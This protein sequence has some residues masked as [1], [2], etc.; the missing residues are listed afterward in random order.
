MNTKFYKNEV[1]VDWDN[2]KTRRLLYDIRRDLAAVDLGTRFYNDL[3]DEYASEDYPQYFIRNVFCFKS[4]ATALPSFWRELTSLK[5]QEV[6]AFFIYWGILSNYKLINNFLTINHCGP[7]IVNVDKIRNKIRN[8]INFLYFY[9]YLDSITL[10][11]I[12]LH[13]L[14]FSYIFFNP[15]VGKVF[16]KALSAY[17]DYYSENYDEADLYQ[18]IAD[19][20]INRIFG[21]EM[22]PFWQ[23]LN[24]TVTK[25]DRVS[26][27]EFDSFLCYKQ[28]IHLDFGD[29]KEV[30]FVGENGDGKTALLMAIFMAFK[31]N[32]IQEN[33]NS[34]EVAA[35][36]D[37]QKKLGSNKEITLRGTDNVG[38]TYTMSYAP[39]IKNFY[40]Y[41]THRGRYSAVTDKDSYDQSGFM[42]LFDTDMTLHDPSDW[43]KNQRLKKPQHERMS[44]DHLANVISELLD[45][46]VEVIF[47]NDKV[48]YSER[49]LRLTLKELSEGYRSTIIFVCDLLTRLSENCPEG[50][51]VFKQPGVVLIDEICQH[52]HPKWQLTIVRKLRKLFPNIQFIMT[53]HSPVIVQ[54]SSKDAIFFRVNRH[55]GVNTISEP[56]KHK[57]IK[58]WMLN[59]II[60]SSLFGMDSA[61]MVGAKAKDVDTSD[62]AIDSRIAKSIKRRV[63][64]E[65]A[66]GKYQLTDDEF[67][68]MMDEIL[69]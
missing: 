10:P 63:E 8:K 13:F 42:T 16:K 44:A 25:G 27:L 52:L 64:E 54:G 48:F 60:T 43:L 9:V 32:S 18:L 69:N 26:T 5:D 49:G 51:D 39:E 34:R 55:E 6:D 47:D 67:E 65:K 21:M 66:Q 61:A 50:E 37:I 45:E 28:P 58:N 19:N 29:S 38:H 62:S 15:E 33:G 4:E 12:K 20:K 24:A 31:A 7:G 1:N 23:W 11:H 35:M 68:K 40:A 22:D 36:L 17:F 14:D 3:K 59:T 57:D 53:T 2:G 46:K 56:L 41:G 30:Y